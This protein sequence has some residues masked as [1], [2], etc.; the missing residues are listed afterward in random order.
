MIP[1]PLNMVLDP[2]RDLV[3]GRSAGEPGLGGGAARARRRPLLITQQASRVQPLREHE[4]HD[5]D[6]DDEEDG[7]AHAATLAQGLR[8][9]RER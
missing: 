9:L 3:R 5:H 8:H 6:R 1:D 7:D 4:P 2:S